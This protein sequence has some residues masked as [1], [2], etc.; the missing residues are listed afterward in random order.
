M[1][2]VA[3]VVRLF[4]DAI[5]AQD[6]LTFDELIDGSCRL[7]CN[8]EL[9]ATDPDGYWDVAQAFRAGFPD[10]VHRSDELIVS[11]DRVTEPFTVTGT[12]TGI[13]HGIEP[14]GRTVSIT[15]TA[16]FRVADGRII[17]D[18]TTVDMLGLLDQIGAVA[19]T[20][21]QA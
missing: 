15:G 4:N 11:G 19:T 20:T 7:Y 9:E 16:V 13:F 1:T 12:H 5:Q 8:D 6:R 17:E 18:R 21:P 14:T 10:L 2:D 3:T